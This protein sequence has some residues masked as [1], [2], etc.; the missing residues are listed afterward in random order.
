[1][2]KFISILALALSLLITP[3]ISSKNTI[4][5]TQI[6]FPPIPDPPGKLIQNVGKGA[7]RDRSKT[8]QCLIADISKFDGKVYLGP[9][10]DSIY[11]VWQLKPAQGDLFTIE[12]LGFLGA[13]GN[14]NYRLLVGNRGNGEVTVQDVPPPNGSNGHLWKITPDGDSFT[15]ENMGN[16]GNPTTNNKYRYLVGN[17]DTGEVK[18]Q[19]TIDSPCSPI[20][21]G[22]G[23]LWN[24]TGKKTFN[25][26]SNE[27]SI[28]RLNNQ[29]QDY[30]LRNPIWEGQELFGNRYSILDTTTRNSFCVT[31]GEFKHACTSQSI[32]NNLYTGSTPLKCDAKLP[33]HIN[34][35]PAIY[36]GKVWFD[37]YEDGAFGDNDVNL[38][39]DT[40]G[41]GLTSGNGKR[42]NY[43]Q[44]QLEFDFTETIGKMKNHPDLKWW[45]E[46][47]K[48]MSNRRIAN[49]YFN[50]NYAIAYGLIGLDGQHDYQSEVHPVFVLAI[51]ANT[52][53]TNDP[54]DEVWQIFVRNKGNEGACSSQLEE[55]KLLNNT[56]FLEIPWRTGFTKVS[57]LRK[58]F[59]ST[60]P[61]VQ[62][63]NLMVGP[64][65]AN[66]NKYAIVKF[67]LNSNDEMLYGELHLIW[68]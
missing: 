65:T 28:N 50:E 24:Y 34:W 11:K 9:K 20:V 55:A 37:S 59:Y 67:Q 3:S 6:R 17:R 48:G 16:S 5:E 43:H 10:T 63:A 54:K 23:D 22:R 7:Y 19:S 14:G 2:I 32:R 33:G 4:I 61:N 35:F 60:N 41:A 49:A 13:P 45:S 38:Q 44:M 27:L 66:P 25:L 57:E 1:M 26:V 58:L 47:E 42:L 53:L 36:E 30:I 64:V 18:L 52:E 46:L 62:N 40:N 68:Q 31:N 12:N 39:M 51:K 56:F 21:C 8:Y 15:I 29:D